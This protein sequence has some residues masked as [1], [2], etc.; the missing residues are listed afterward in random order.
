MA[1]ARRLTHYYI[2]YRVQG[3]V[4]AARKAVD[5]LI[6]DLGIQCA[7]KGRVLVRRDDPRTW[8]EIYERVADADAFELALA[9]AVVRHGCARFCES[10]KRHVEP[11]VAA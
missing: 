9:A 5:A 4:V 8:M 3:D 11:F 2:Y 7:V 1:P 6:R 10:G